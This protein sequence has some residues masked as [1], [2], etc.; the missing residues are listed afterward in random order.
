MMVFES[1]TKLDRRFLKVSIPDESL[2]KFFQTGE[3]HF[4]TTGLPADSVLV[5]IAGYDSIFHTVELIVHSKEFDLIPED[6][7]ICNCPRY[8]H[9]NLFDLRSPVVTWRVAA[10]E[11]KRGLEADKVTISDE[12]FEVIGLVITWENPDRMLKVSVS[13]NL[14]LAKVVM[15]VRERLETTGYCP[16]VSIPQ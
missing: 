15:Q 7:S 12:G 4:A 9:I 3:H 1:A 2:I 13:S 10:E 5:G 14:P 8:G 16:V 11:I 6:Q